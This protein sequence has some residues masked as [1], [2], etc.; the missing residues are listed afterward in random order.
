[1]LHLHLLADTDRLDGFVQLAAFVVAVAGVSELARLLG[2]SS[3]VQ[4]V[5]AVIA[6][7]VPSAILEGTSTQN[8]LFAAVRRGRP[9]RDRH[10]LGAAGRRGGPGHR[11]RPHRG[12][13]PSEQGNL[14]SPHRAGGPAARCSHR[15][16]GG[17]AILVGG[18]RPP[19]GRRRGRGGGLRAAR[20]R[21]FRQAKPRP[22]R[23]VRRPGDP[24]HDE[25]RGLGT[26]Q[27]GQRGAQRRGQLQDRE[28]GR[29]PRQ[30]DEPVHAGRAPPR[31][32]VDGR[33]DV[34]P[35]VHLGLAGRCLR[36]PATSPR[37]SATRTTAPTPGTCC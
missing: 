3:G 32:R 13:Q 28:R 10:G 30:R 21:T 1:M 24:G 20:R 6:A 8:N 37:S 19:G 29:R 36:S 34:R 7:T 25:R 17:S 5:A 9:A 4:V 27:R 14:G 22:L 23:L 18:G 35:R 16:R 11:P 31:V 15:A 2:G 26:G 12:A 33:P